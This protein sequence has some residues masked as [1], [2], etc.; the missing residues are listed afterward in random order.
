MD[1]VDHRGLIWGL[2]MQRTNAAC[3]QPNS[4]ALGCELHSPSRKAVAFGEVQSAVASALAMAIMKLENVMGC[5]A[6]R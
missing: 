2:V 5:E 4:G 1:G 6:A 3:L